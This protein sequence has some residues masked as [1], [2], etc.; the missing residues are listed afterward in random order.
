LRFPPFCAQ[1]PACTRCTQA[2]ER[3]SPPQIS[4][5]TLRPNHRQPL[6]SFS[7]IFLSSFCD[8]LFLLVGV[9]SK[10]RDPYLLTL[11]RLDWPPFCGYVFPF[12]FFFL[13]LFFFCFL[14][15]TQRVSVRQYARSQVQYDSFFSSR[16]LDSAFT[17]ISPLL[18]APPPFRGLSFLRQDLVD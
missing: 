2:S 17:K 15:S 13:F 5:H 14:R 18:S 4:S 1:F 11:R 3:H 12:S 9:M 8:L 6:F 16:V 10:T 7:A